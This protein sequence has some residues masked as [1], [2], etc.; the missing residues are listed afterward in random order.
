MFLSRR[1]FL[2]I[3]RKR[4]FKK[5]EKMNTENNKIIAKFLDSKIYLKDTDGYSKPLSVFN[6]K[7]L[8][9]DS[10]WNWLM[11][12]IFKITKLGVSYDDKGNE[13]FLK[14]GENLLMLKIQPTYDA[15]FDLIKWYNEQK[16]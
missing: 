2:P 9:F 14:I 15:V 8:K 12:V 6:S 10:D 13:L 5:L 7:D 1:Y 4:N 11:E 3:E 16:S